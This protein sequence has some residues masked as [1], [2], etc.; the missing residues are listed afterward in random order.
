MSFWH[1]IQ[2]ELK[3]AGPRLILFEKI[4]PIGSEFEPLGHYA[5]INY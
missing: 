3:S 2:S 1:A 4:G 5:V